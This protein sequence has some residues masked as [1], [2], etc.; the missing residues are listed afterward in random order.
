MLNTS[1]TPQRGRRL[2]RSIIPTPQRLQRRDI[3][4][5][6]VSPRRVLKHSQQSPTK[7]R[8][9]S[10]FPSLSVEDIR[11]A[12]RNDPSPLARFSKDTAG[13]LSSSPSGSVMSGISREDASEA[14]SNFATRNLSVDLEMEDM[15]VPS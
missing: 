11:A 6:S 2:E 5:L 9:R 1:S 12:S 7:E 3:I 13:M 14:R 4:F 8:G 15:E 10:A